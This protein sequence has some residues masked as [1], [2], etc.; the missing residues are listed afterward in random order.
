MNQEQFWRNFSLNREL[1]VA[2]GFIYDGM[3]ELRPL[4]S[5]DNADEVF[6]VVYPLAVGFER[7]LKIAIVLLEYKKGTD[8]EEF[9]KSLITH[10]HLELLR[11][12]KAAAPINLA[13]QH[14][15]FLQILGKFYKSYRYDRFSIKSVFS[16]SSESEELLRLLRKHIPTIEGR[17]DVF[18]GEPSCP[19]E[20]RVFVARVCQKISTA[21]Y[22]II[23]DAARAV[24]LFT[25]EIRY[26]SKAYKVFLSEEL[27]FFKE[28]LLWKEILVFLMNT[29]EETGVLK[30]LRDIQPLDFDS[31]MISDYLEC[32]GSDTKK[33][34]HIEEL[35]ELYRQ[36]DDPSMRQDMMGVIGGGMYFID[37]DELEEYEEA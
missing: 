6:Q 9:E 17:D 11:R 14:N 4:K 25:Y 18:G 20:V 33:I 29:S 26:A 15:E 2:G 13:P 10:N 28:D 23:E 19:D 21:L 37:D 3:R 22:G 8:Q 27:D 34:E 7:L 24:N 5:F 12:V 16:R 1:H 30:F 32:L 35:K 36:I 31:G